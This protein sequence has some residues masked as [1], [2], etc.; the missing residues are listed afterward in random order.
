MEVGRQGALL[1]QASPPGMWPHNH[2]TNAL[3]GPRHNAHLR[4]DDRGEGERVAWQA[5][6]GRHAARPAGGRRRQRVW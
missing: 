6:V 3:A 1:L 2:G 5:V 4:L